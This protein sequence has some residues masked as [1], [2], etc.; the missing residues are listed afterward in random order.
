MAQAEVAYAHMLWLVIRGSY[1][2]GLDPRFRE[3]TMTSAA[4]PRAQALPSECRN[5]VGAAV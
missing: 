1:R 2:Q 4:F 5:A 3:P